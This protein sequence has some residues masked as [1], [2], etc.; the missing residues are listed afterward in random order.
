MIKK[1]FSFSNKKT[2][3]YFSADFNFLEQLNEKTNTVLVT[4]ENI[5]NYHGHRFAG[6]KTIVVKAGELN[7]TQ[8]TVDSIITELIKFEADRKFTVVGIGGGV[9][10]DLAG[11]AASIYM[12]G[13]RFGFLPVS[14]LAMVDASIGGKNGVDVGPYKNLVGV[15]RQPDFLLY[16]SSFLSS[17]PEQEWTNGFAEIIKHACIKDA[18]LFD[19]LEKKSVEEYRADQPSLDKLIQRNAEIKCSVVQNDE[20]EKGERKLLNFGHTWGHAIETKLNIPHG[21]AVSIGMV[22]ACRLS[23]LITGFSETDRLIALLKQY[24]LPVSAEVNKKEV[25]DVLKMDK[26]KDSN[27]M[28][29]VLLNNIGEG[30]IHKIPMD[31]LWKMIE[32]CK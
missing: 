28:N 1:S 19:E 2:D 5:F 32:Q 22:L 25:F 8:A 31:E 29:Y 4:D 7:K 20:F 23:E 21:H 18:N 16:D 30:V 12:R 27:S 17:L 26:K 10:T 15:I 3:F 14:I 6:W 13:L 11:Y 24:G 9:I